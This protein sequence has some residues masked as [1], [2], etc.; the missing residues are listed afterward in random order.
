MYPR[1]FQSIAHGRD[2]VPGKAVRWLLAKASPPLVPDA[3]ERV[4]GPGPHTAP[5]HARAATQAM[6]LAQLGPAEQVALTDVSL[7][8]RAVAIAQR[9]APLRSAEEIAGRLGARRVA[10][11]ARRARQVSH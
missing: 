10:A 3:L 2:F 5:D 11:R 4:S 6:Q 7:C 1:L 8:L 9:G